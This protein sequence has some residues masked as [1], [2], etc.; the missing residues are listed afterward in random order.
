M[1]HKLQN[2]QATKHSS[3]KT[4]KDMAPKESMLLK[5]SIC[6]TNIIS[7]LMLYHY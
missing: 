4:I 6:I 7:L 3:Y 5:D 2:I 1:L